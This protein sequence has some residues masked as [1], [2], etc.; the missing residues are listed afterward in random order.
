MDVLLFDNK[1]LAQTKTKVAVNEGIFS[2]EFRETLVWQLLTTYLAGARQWSKSNL[3]RSD[4][5]GGGKKPWRQKG[6][7]NARHG[8]TRSPIWRHGGVTFA[9]NSVKRDMKLN[10]KMYRGGMRSILAEQQ[11]AGALMVV[12]TLPSD[13]QKTKAATEWLK[14]FEGKRVWILTSDL[15][16]GLVMSTRNLHRVN[17]VE[18]TRV[19]PVFV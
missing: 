1:N 5:S 11:R 18:A 4:V 2:T 7:G 9:A 13:I 6:T 16:E 15:N 8:S 10:K 12:E 19:D 3:S 17:V 14:A